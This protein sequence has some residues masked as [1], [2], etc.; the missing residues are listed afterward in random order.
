M[1]TNVGYQGYSYKL[2][3]LNTLR[4]CMIW[5]SNDI[6]TIRFSIYANVIVDTHWIVNKTYLQV[7]GYKLNI[8][9]FNNEGST[10]S[11]K[12][13]YPLQTDS[14]TSFD[15]PWFFAIWMGIRMVKMYFD[16]V[17]SIHAKNNTILVIVES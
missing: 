4:Y 16:P 11:N 8:S 12:A 3:F 13:G 6:H 10:V 9:A 2:V 1:F 5:E 14:N 7:R 17:I 15:V